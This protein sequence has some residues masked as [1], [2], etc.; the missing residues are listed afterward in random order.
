MRLTFIVLT[1]IILS[2]NLRENIRDDGP[3]M[4]M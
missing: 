1:V 2:V 4:Y 3:Q